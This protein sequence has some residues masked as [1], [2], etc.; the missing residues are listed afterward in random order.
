MATQESATASE[1]QEKGAKAYTASITSSLLLVL[2]LR[3]S[4]P[5]RDNQIGRGACTIVQ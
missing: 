4:F 1:C 3:E 2:L 5:S